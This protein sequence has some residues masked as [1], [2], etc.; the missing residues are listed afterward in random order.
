MKRLISYFIK[1]PISADVLVVVIL[2]FGFIGLTNLRSTFFPENES[3]LIA[4]RTIYPGASPEEVEEGIIIKIEDNLKGLTGIERVT[5]VSQENLGSVL[6]EIKR[7]YDI[8]LLVQ[9][10]KNAVDEINTFP[11]GME[12]PVVYK[13]EVLTVA[14][15]F[16]ISG[17]TDL[18]TLKRFARNIESDLLANPKISKVELSGFPEEEI[19]IS[20]READL[21]AYNL[22]FDQVV[23][24]V[25]GSNIE[26]TGGTIKAEN[27]ELLIRADS[28]GYFANEFTNLIEATAPDGR[29][30]Y[31]EDVANVTDRWEDTPNRVYINGNPGV[32]IN[33]SNTI[34]ENL[35]DIST[36]VGEYVK[37]FNEENSVIQAVI[38][39]DGSEVLNQRI[40]LLT[41]N[42]V[43]GFIF[44]LII[45][46]MFLKVR[47][48]FWVAIAIPVSF[49]GM[50]MMAGFFSVSINVISLFGMILVIGILVDDGIVIGENIYRR[51]EK[52]EDPYTAALNGTMEVLP[53]VLGAILT[54]M[55]AFGSFI[56]LEGITGDFF[57]EMAIVVILT[58]GF[59]LIE[60]A[61]ILPAHISHSKDL[62]REEDKEAKSG[63]LAPVW[64]SLERLQQIFW[65]F[66]DWAKDKVYA[67]ILRF[68]MRNALL[69]F[70]IPMALL[71]I[72][73][74]L[75]QGGFVKNTIFPVIEN[76]YVT[77]SLKMPSGTREHVTEKWL[78]HIEDGIWRVNEAEKAKRADGKNVVLIS[79]KIL[80]SGTNE[81][82][83]SVRLL[84]T[85]TRNSS[86]L[87][88]SDA[89]RQE[90]GPILEA[91]NLSY[92]VATP[93][94]APVSIAVMSDNLKVLDQAVN[95][96]KEELE[97]LS[98]LRDITD[99]NQ[100][101]LREV[102]IQL[103]DKALLLGLNEQII[104][105][106]VRQGFF[107]AE[108]QRLQR[109]ID[110]VKVWVR[111][112]EEDRSSIG[113]LEDMRIRTAGGQTYPLKELADFVPTRGV[114][115]INRL[116]GKREVRVEADISST[117]VSTSDVN[118][119]IIEDI[120]PPILAKYSEISYS[121][122]GQVRENAKTIE[123]SKT[124]IP[125]AVIM[126][127][128]IIILTFRSFNQTIAVLSVI[129]FGM[130]GVIWGH[131]VFDK[132]LSLFSIL[133]IFALVGIIINDALV[134]VSA[135]NN[136]I[137]EGKSFNEA[138][139][140]AG[141]SRFRPIFLTSLTT[142]AGLAPLIFEK[143]FQA[144]F[145]VPMAI[146]VACGLAVATAIILIL[147]PVML[148]ILNQYK[149][150]TLGFWEKEKIEP[151]MVEP[152]LAGR[153]KNYFLWTAIPAAVG[154]L[155]FL[156]SQLFA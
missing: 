3:K 72:S 60:G 34:D 61:F 8:E 20:V 2:I 147:L 55:I 75:L 110:E 10:V 93:F 156:I 77:V 152:A 84:D 101:G 73:F 24:A 80:G 151:E 6:V 144:Q 58:L 139:Y 59:S 44:V 12:S 124:V 48:A 37:E 1:Y 78:D 27:E 30:V 126:M 132:P 79:T 31:L 96:V 121:L 32:A 143:S 141:L 39:N 71:L 56:F 150:A 85:E 51:W 11:D 22:T 100:E 47:L 115:A 26:L 118:N 154:S 49:M 91:E 76:D 113:K 64:D 74:G 13:Q 53:A 148:V 63:F 128:V 92:A 107:G 127:I 145:L 54:T 104:A 16:A 134:L 109:G 19:E 15:N 125:I 120:M 95:E 117:D 57:S 149:T 41:E 105:G 21:R 17:D 45:L 140:E 108:V 35:L 146:S 89:F 99:S 4:V 18:R 129:P 98:D 62:K 112:T 86:S 103:K 65:G 7:G 142:I 38:I 106:Q 40:D 28:K 153:K 25:Q 119:T 155:I 130:I 68:M 123:S 43:L 29:R 14:L 50:F 67:P 136:L 23:R 82:V 111:Y 102:N 36:A 69:G 42:G 5:S 88:L 70:A 133:G 116:D 138:I 83:I 122:E 114:L 135:F 66:L 9:D 90:V 131:W 94:G 87:A 97:K 81:G 137:K 33:V 52:G 46:A